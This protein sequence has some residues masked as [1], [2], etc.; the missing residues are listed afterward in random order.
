MLYI[1]FKCYAVSGWPQILFQLA[2]PRIG[3]YLTRLTFNIMSKPFQIIFRWSKVGI[4]CNLLISNATVS[5]WPQ[6]L[7][8]LAKSRIE[9]Y[10]T[11]LTFNIMSEPFQIIF[12]CT[13]VGIGCNLLILNATQ[14]PDAF[15]YYFNW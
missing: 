1:H 15:Q 8:Q 6:V 5:G 12:G 10:L 14:C 7:F 4:G 3:C 9:C 11:R 13:K 2:K